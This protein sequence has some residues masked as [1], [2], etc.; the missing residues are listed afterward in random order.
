MEDDEKAITVP[1]SVSTLPP[2]VDTE[3]VNP[4]TL[5]VGDKVVILGQSRSGKTTLI[6][7]LVHDNHH[8]FNAIWAF[9]GTIAVSQNYLWNE[10]FIIQLNAPIRL[11]E[12]DHV[13]Q[14]KKIIRLQEVVAE[15]C[16]E[17]GEPIPPMLLIF[18]DCLCMDFYEDSTFWGGWLSDLRHYALSV[19]FSIQTP[20]HAIPPNMR[21]Q[22][23]KEYLFTSR[24]DSKLVT[25]MIP[26][27]HYQGKAYTGQAAYDMIC[28]LLAVKYQC[29]FFDSLN[30]VHGHLF[31]T[32]P[33]KPFVI[34]YGARSTVSH[35]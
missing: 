23:D 12:D 18:D 17:K 13:T 25:S 34:S 32:A 3:G 14:I 35:R 21:S 9:C 33:T 22:T 15:T 10:P 26:P 5:D 19:I 6:E 24:A 30:G 11:G 2:V 1:S 29:L 31:T 7:R 8:K 16:R 4:T 20:H 27:L 28:K